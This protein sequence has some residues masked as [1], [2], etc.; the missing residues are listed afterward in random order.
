MIE[1][2]EKLSQNFEFVRMDF[3]ID[4]NDDIYFSEF[5]FTPNAGTRVFTDE[6]EISL[7]K[8]WI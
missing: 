5:T 7:G 4:K 2:A 3:H 1:Y 6:W 8:D